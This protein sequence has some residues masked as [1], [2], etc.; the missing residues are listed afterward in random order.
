VKF[1]E[2]LACGVRPILTPHVGD[3]SDLCMDTGHGVVVGLADV[4]LAA[5]RVAEDAAHAGTI[6]A[7]GR[8]RRRAWAAEYVA[9]ARVAARILEF[10]DRIAAAR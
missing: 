3:Q 9:P 1:G 10:L 6:D 7:E 5:Q 8:A 2:Y 4:T